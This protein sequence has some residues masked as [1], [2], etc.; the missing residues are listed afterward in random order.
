MTPRTTWTHSSNQSTHSGY[1]SCK[2]SNPDWYSTV[3]A[4]LRLEP[5]VFQKYFP[6][7]ALHLSVWTYS[8]CTATLSF[9]HTPALR[10]LRWTS[11]E[12]RLM[13]DET[14]RRPHIRWRA[15]SL[16]PTCRRHNNS[17]QQG[18]Q[19]LTGT[20]LTQGLMWNS[21]HISSLLFPCLNT[22]SPALAE[23]HVMVSR[24]VRKRQRKSQKG[25]WRKEFNNTPS[26]DL[27]LSG[28]VFLV[29]CFFRDGVCQ[30]ARLWWNGVC[31]L[32]NYS[33]LCASLSLSA[34]LPNPHTSTCARTQT[35]KLNPNQ[36]LSDTFHMISFKMHPIFPHQLLWPVAFTPRYDKHET[37]FYWQQFLYGS[38][39][40]FRI[41]SC[42]HAK[43]NVEK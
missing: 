2:D 32:L 28:D 25:G 36:S 34:I 23:C 22:L 40:Q 21:L 8:L 24:L 5:S 15:A 6:A 29:L 35:H 13:K 43:I 38:F 27:S 11:A 41:I 16:L 26:H 10:K 39:C 33:L 3:A 19:P 7:A 14:H 30:A 18:S 12:S 31:G 17:T 37:S 1:N 42:K 9:N 20:R 4:G